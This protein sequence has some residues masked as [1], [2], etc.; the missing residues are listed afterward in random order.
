MT[1]LFS[2]LSQIAA[3]VIAITMVSSV[4]V[5]QT[6]NPLRLA[7]PCVVGSSADTLAR[8][9]A[10][11]VAEELGRPVFVENRPAHAVVAQA[12]STQSSHKES[13]SAHSEAPLLCRE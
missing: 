7:V 2:L 10:Q 5:A 9:F 12:K 11:M 4:A 13:A 3:P 6:D 8:S 1:S